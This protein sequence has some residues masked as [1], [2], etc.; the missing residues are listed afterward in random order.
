MNISKNELVIIWLAEYIPNLRKV[1]T[2]VLHTN[3]SQRKMIS[4]LTF[5]STQKYKIFDLETIYIIFN[6]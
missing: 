4:K 1:N 3:N 2:N 5:A 6:Y